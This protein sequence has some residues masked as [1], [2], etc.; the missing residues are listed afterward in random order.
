MPPDAPVPRLRPGGALFGWPLR[1]QFLDH[2]FVGFAPT[3]YTTT[4]TFF[5]LC[6]ASI[7]CLSLLSPYC[8]PGPFLSLIPHYTID[9][10]QW[11]R[12]P[13]AG[14]QVRRRL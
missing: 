7:L 2:S 6:L 11:T 14:G 10:S 1:K 5:S 9:P 13:S 8:L 12:D 4:Q 3:Y